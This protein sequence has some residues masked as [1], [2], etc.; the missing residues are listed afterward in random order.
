M[1]WDFNSALRVT[2]SRWYSVGIVLQNEQKCREGPV[3]GMDVPLVITGEAW[4][5]SLSLLVHLKAAY[6]PN[7]FYLLHNLAVRQTSKAHRAN[8]FTKKVFALANYVITLGGMTP[9]K[10]RTTSKGSPYMEVFYAA[11]KV[12]RKT[13]S[14]LKQAASG[15]K[16]HNEPMQGL[17]FN[18]ADEKLPTITELL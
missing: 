16:L 13:L 18:D 7:P 10:E 2:A 3:L 9:P 6:T 14:F 17:V 12:T 8:P 11:M 1:T 5:T 15:G 4:V